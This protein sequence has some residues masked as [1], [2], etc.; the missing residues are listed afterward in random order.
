MKR[1]LLLSCLL[2]CFHFASAQLN[3]TFRSQLSFP[4]I[5]ASN[6]WG[7]VDSLGNEYA[8]VGTEDGVRIIDVTNPVAPVQKFLVP[9]NT[10][11]WREI[12]T[13]GKYA[14]VTTEATAPNPGILVINL[15]NLPGPVTTK[16]WRG[17]GAINN[18]L[19]K[20]HALHVEAGYLY[21]YGTNLFSGAALIVNLADPWNPVYM[22]YCSG[23]VSSPYVHDGY[24]RNDT[25][26]AGHIYGGY[27]AVWNVTN[28]S[29]PVLIAYLNTPG[30]F[31]HNTWLTDNSRILLTT[32]EVSNS[33]LTAYDISDPMNITELDRIQSQFPSSGSI[34]HNT[35]VRNDFAITSWYRDGITIV[36]AGRRGN[37]VTT[38]YYDC[39]A[40]LS[41][42]GFNSVWGVY[43]FLPSGNLVLSDIEQGLIVLTP[44]YVRACYLEGLVTDSI[45]GVPL[46]NVLVEILSTAVTDLTKI[47]GLYKTG[48]TT[49]GTY[50]IRFSKAGYITKTITG[51][52]LANGLAT[53]LD[54]QLA[55]LTSFT[56]TGIVKSNVNG[57]PIPFG[58]VRFENA[59]Y[60]YATTT[61]A[62]GNFTISNFYAGTYN[63]T[64]GKWLYKNKCVTMNVTS[65][66]SPVTFLCDTG[67]YDDFSFSY[68]WTVTGNA[69]T[70][71]WV[72]GV[73]VG[74]T[75]ATT[76]DANPA[77]DV[78]P[79]CSKYCYVTGNGGGTYS[80]D[81]V[82]N[83]STTLTSPLFNL[84][85]YSDPY[86]NYSRWFFNIPS[87]S[88]AN[89]TLRISITNGLTTA[90]LENV[91]AS[92][93]PGMS[94]WVSKSFKVSS[95][96]T[97][98]ANMRIIVY[99][100][101]Q[102]ATANTLEAGFDFFNVT[103]SS[104]LPVEM[105]LFDAAPMD[106]YNLLSWTTMS[107]INNYGFEI[108]KSADG[109]YFVKTGFVKGAGNST[110]RNE[111]EFKDHLI[112][113][114]TVYYRLK[115][116][117][118]NS[119]CNYSGIAVVKRKS[120]NSNEFAVIYPNPVA[121]EFTIL[122]ADKTE[123]PS[124]LELSDMCGR[125]MLER[126]IEQDVKSEKVR[127]DNPSFMPGIY[128][129]RITSG[130]N[131]FFSKILKR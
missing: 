71:A 16:Y 127:L 113:P 48:I 53:I 101:D 43:P 27:F 64:A 18:L 96:I 3:V 6:I 74:T 75:Y 51:V 100:A 76:G 2:I 58:N 77:A 118:Y 106:N 22:G 10:S 12:K 67:I 1:Y 15:S 117:D 26:Y 122:F 99:T 88:P 66:S 104:P 30:N 124:V 84:T 47:T 60:A 108:E 112:E 11:F 35:H 128:Q 72:R 121:E 57:A 98:T 5:E 119:A 94:Q 34:V 54:V 28:K 82:D 46:A 37:L 110:G 93:A 79:D 4:G 41:G 40:A 50:S 20:A 33:Y 125:I 131:L 70:G 63:C 97:P 81:D 17:T 120:G 91:I 59:N 32:D 85:S 89:D 19:T 102:A 69:A 55:P 29:A 21:L 38:G 92:T 36:D 129:L 86:V 78:T 13:W 24:V 7:Y 56:L 44:N 95:Y 103:N 9:G 126:T 23:P 39:N 111:Y 68:A 49:A 130:S 83:G 45:T 80:F 87:G 114:G 123:D 115:Q 42:N 90:V 107:E 31:T 62:S 109:K 73:P 25:L 14:Y 116:V 65:A 105:V 52:S 61:N 8:L